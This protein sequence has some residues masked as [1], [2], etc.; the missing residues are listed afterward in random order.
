MNAVVEAGMMT[1]EVRVSFC[2]YN[3]SLPSHHLIALYDLIGLFPLV[4]IGGYDERRGGGRDDRR[5]GRD[6]RSR[7]RDRGGR[8]PPQEGGGAAGGW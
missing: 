4:T 6:D 1:E 5:G 2:D 7:S 8:G 3:H